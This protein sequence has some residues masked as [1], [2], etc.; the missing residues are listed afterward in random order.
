[1]DGTTNALLGLGEVCAMFLM[2][3]GGATLLLSAWYG[4]QCAGRVW[5]EAQR[6]RR[7]QE[8]VDAALDK[9]ADGG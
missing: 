3:L 7:A 6:E 5:D 2:G 1:M 8:A 4:L 9:V